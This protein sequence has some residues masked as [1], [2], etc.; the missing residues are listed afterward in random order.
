MDNKNIHRIWSIQS[1]SDSFS[2]NNKD[3][4]VLFLQT[5]ALISYYLTSL[6]PCFLTTISLSL[7]CVLY[8]AE[9]LT[10]CLFNN[11]EPN[12]GWNL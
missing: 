11:E 2:F 8:R 5:S 6:C 10:M 7:N 12:L 3:I 1:T 4:L 9:H